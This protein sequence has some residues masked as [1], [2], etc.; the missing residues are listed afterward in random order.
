MDKSDNTTMTG[1]QD[2]PL[3]KN[4]NKLN[5][6]ISLRRLCLFLF[7]SLTGLLLFMV[8]MPLDGRWTVPIAYLINR[9][10]A[11]VHP[12]MAVLTLLIVVVPSVVSTTV[13]LSPKLRQHQHAFWRLF[14]TTPLWLAIRLAGTASLLMVYYQVGPDW[15]WDQDTGGVLLAEVAPVLLT[16]FFLSAILLPLLTDYGLMEFVSVLINRPFQRLF[17]LP[18][19]AA[20][21]CLASWLSASSVGILLTSQQYHDGHY[22]RRQASTIATNYSIVSIAFAYVLLSFVHLEHVFIGWYL[23]VSLAGIACALIIPRLPPLS[24]M[25]NLTKDNLPLQPDR[26]DRNDQETLLGHALRR[27]IERAEAALPPVTKLK[28]SLY[29]AADLSITVYPTMMIFGVVGLAI[30]KYTPLVDI[31]AAPLV[32][33]LKLFGL[34]E[35]GAAATAMLAGFIDLLMP[36]I[37]GADIQ[38]ELTRFV[39]AGVAVNGIIFLTEVAVVILKAR[40]GLNLLHMFI[41]WILRLLIAVP[42]LSLMGRFVL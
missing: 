4:A 38:S 8:P 29:A 31:L 19:R 24:R 2:T 28:R 39:I 10:T 23:S 22:T 30:I 16:L 14:H 35:A 42:I 13:I 18:G 11:L 20:I 33:Y 41:I 12:Y 32:P 21:D 25:S 3:L 27:G 6:S 26:D 5:A 36:V 15:V 7:P 9:V 17:K 1:P 37:L 34:P 40:I